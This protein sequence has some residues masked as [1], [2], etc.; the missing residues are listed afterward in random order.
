[1]VAAVD[2]RVAH[3]DERRTHVSAEVQAIEAFFRRRFGRDA[4]YLPSGRLGRAS[5]HAVMTTN[6]YGIPDRVR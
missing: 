2:G 1:M 4:L 6:L 5:S 3:I